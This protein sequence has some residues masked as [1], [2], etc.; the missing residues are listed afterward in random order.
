[1]GYFVGFTSGLMS[2]RTIQR[3]FSKRRAFSED[4]LLLAG[5]REAKRK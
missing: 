5:I 1:M 2:I 4:L 3:G